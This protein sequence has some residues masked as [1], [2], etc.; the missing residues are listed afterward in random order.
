MKILTP[1]I[2]LLPIFISIS[3]NG[4]DS[5][6][7]TSALEDNITLAK[8]TG[9]DPLTK[10]QLPTTIPYAYREEGNKIPFELFIQAPNALHLCIVELY[11]VKAVSCNHIHPPLNANPSAMVES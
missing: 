5:I 8:V 3:F 1:I 9:L 6:H 7:K 2:F 11:N 10:A 4:V